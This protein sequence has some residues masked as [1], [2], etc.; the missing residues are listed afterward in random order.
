MTIVISLDHQVGW[1]CFH[2]GSIQGTGQRD[3]HK[4]PYLLVIFCDFHVNIVAILIGRVDLLVHLSAQSLEEQ[5]DEMAHR[6]MHLIH[7]HQLGG[8]Q[9]HN[10]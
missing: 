5:K 2:I 3:Q 9:G 4:A 7:T 1:I 6:A 10:C 8:L